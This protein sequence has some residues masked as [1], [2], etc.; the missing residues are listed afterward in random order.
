MPLSRL[1]DGLAADV[2]SVRAQLRESRARADR[3]AGGMV[4]LEG[5]AAAY[6]GATEAMQAAAAALA[7]ALRV[8][9]GTPPALPMALTEAGDS[10]ALLGMQAGVLYGSFAATEQHAKLAGLSKV[11]AKA[12]D[13]AEKEAAKCVL[14]R[15]AGGDCG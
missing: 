5:A 1:L 9:P 3:V 11:A 4:T 7:A 15:C 13:A 8:L 2:P 6:A 14:V 10:A 12:R